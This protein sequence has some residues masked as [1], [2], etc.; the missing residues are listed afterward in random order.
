MMIVVMV[1]IIRILHSTYRVYRVEYSFYVGV[2]VYMYV[3]IFFLCL[4]DNIRKQ[5]MYTIIYIY[6]HIYI[7]LHVCISVYIMAIDSFS[8][9]IL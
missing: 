5:W 8:L 1:H 6:T 7:V 2:H 4:Y 3:W 9:Y